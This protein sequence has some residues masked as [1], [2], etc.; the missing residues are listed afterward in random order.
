MK[1]MQLLAACLAGLLLCQPL[2]LHAETTD[3]LPVSDGEDLTYQ[4][5]ADGVLTIR[6]EGSLPTWECGGYSVKPDGV[7]AEFGIELPPWY[8]N[9]NDI[10]EIVLEEGITL[11]SEQSFIGCTN[12]TSISFPSTLTTIAEDAFMGCYNLEFLQLGHC[13]NLTCIGDSAFGYAYDLKEITLPEGLVTLYGNAFRGSAIT[14]LSLPASLTELKGELFLQCDALSAFSVDADNPAYTSVEGVLFDKAGTTLLRYPMTGTAHLILPEQVEVIGEK[15]FAWNDQLVQVYL[16]DSITEIRPY[17]FAYCTALEFLRLPDAVTN[18]PT[19]SCFGCASLSHIW[20]PEALT[21]VGDNAL[22]T[23]SMRL[24]LY[25]AGTQAAWDALGITTTQP[26]AGVHVNATEDTVMAS[27]LNGSGTVDARDASIIL[28]YAAA[29]ASG[30]TPDLIRYRMEREERIYT[31]H[32]L[33]EQPDA[34]VAMD[35]TQD[36]LTNA[37]DVSVLLQ[38]AAAAG[39][40]FDEG[41]AAFLAAR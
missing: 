3:W 1:R 41:L 11:I 35:L 4:L 40:G 32:A 25:Y 23:A 39:A 38:Y 15:A 6:G 17:A 8:A 26:A 14:S 21:T 7:T 34:C 33:P 10:K 28:Q 19:G 36:T 20:L 2:P 37:A 9:R 27:D 12:V 18:L 22:S 5:D 29:L 24:W 31:V 16:P 30:N 13:L